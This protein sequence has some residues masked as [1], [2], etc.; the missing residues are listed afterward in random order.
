MCMEMT[1]KEGAAFTD[2]QGGKIE[3]GIGGNITQLNNLNATAYCSGGTNE[4]KL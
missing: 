3:F 1:R 4:G 2:V